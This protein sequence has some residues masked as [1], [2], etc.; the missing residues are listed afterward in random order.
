MPIYTSGLFL[1]LIQFLV[2]YFLVCSP[3]HLSQRQKPGKKGVGRKQGKKE[4]SGFFPSFQCRLNSISSKEVSQ[5]VPGGV[6]L[7]SSCPHGHLSLVTCLSTGAVARTLAWGPQLEPQNDPP[8]FHTHSV[9]PLSWDG[10]PGMNRAEVWGASGRLFSLRDE[11]VS[12]P[13]L[14]L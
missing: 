14:T 11:G 13:D 9:L 4:V 2:R 12:Q 1:L 5:F 6:H 8:G 10:S 3:N 7:P